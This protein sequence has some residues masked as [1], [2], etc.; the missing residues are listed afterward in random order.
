MN[1]EKFLSKLKEKLSSLPYSEMQERVNFY[2]EMIDDLM[3]EGLSE[4]DAVLKVGNA[5]DIASE[6][7]KDVPFND[8]VEEKLKT[9]KK[10]KGL[11]IALLIM[12]SPVWF[13][14]LV[15]IASVAFSLIIATIAVIFS[16]IVVLFAIVISLWAVVFSLITCAIASVIICIVYIFSG[17]ALSGFAVLSVGF[18]CA[19]LSI[20]GFF[21]CKKLTYGVVLLSK[22]LIVFIKTQFNKRRKA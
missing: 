6:I 12:G 22:S 20:F 19:G 16:L 15:V 9:S 21:G 14:I 3:E 8:I 5:D 2:S 11:K 10:T 17:H 4:K 13:S 7:V 1:K 18:T